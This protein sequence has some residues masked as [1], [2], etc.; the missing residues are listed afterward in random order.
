MHSLNLP[1]HE[2]KLLAELDFVIVSSRGILVLEIKGGRVNYGS[3]H[4]WTTE[5]RHG[6]SRL[7]ESP[8]KQAQSGMYALKER[9]YKRSG[10]DFFR[11]IP[12]G[13]G[14]VFPDVSFTVD[15]TLEWDE[16][17]LLDQRGFHQE[18]GLRGYLEDLL[19]YWIEK[20]NRR[21]EFWEDPERSLLDLTK[22]R[23]IQ[24]MARPVFELVPNLNN[25]ADTL[26][27]LQEEATRDQYRFIDIFDSNSRV[28]CYGGAGSGKTFLALE[29]AIRASVRGDRVLLV[30]RNPALASFLQGRVTNGSARV[31]SID[32]LPASETYDLLIVDEGQDLMAM[33]YLDLL[34]RCLDGGLEKGNWA[35]FYDQHNQSGIYNTFDSDALLYLESFCQ[36][37]VPLTRNL[38]NTHPIVLQTKLLTGADLGTASA[39]PGPPVAYNYYKS[40]NE[41]AAALNEQLKLWLDD[42]VP[43][44]DITILSPVTR[45]NSCAALLG[46][47]GDQIRTLSDDFGSDFPCQEL[48]F[49]DITGFKGLENRFIALVDLE[50][51][52]SLGSSLSSLY[53]GMTRARAGLWLSVNQ[54]ISEEIVSIQLK[55][56]AVIPGEGE[57]IHD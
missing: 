37:R 51:I 50:T 20:H 42:D 54:S 31:A 17:T 35:I 3:D 19:N 4:I 57:S 43:P 5:G 55:H 22:I 6:I 7:S 9:L 40:R 38:R 36:A 23:S 16:E 25:T 28:L 33:A 52:D 34:D 47:R 11:D 12:Y 39:G 10:S 32:Q 46:T 8:F 13:F 53:V 30:C 21:A 2:Y 41:A 14:V 29:T 24:D 27:A 49:C 48:T 26:D 1:E 18:G 15:S 45:E 44:G 56:I